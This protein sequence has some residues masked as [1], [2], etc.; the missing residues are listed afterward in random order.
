M[1]KLLLALGI[2]L[3]FASCDNGGIS[4]ESNPFVGAWEADDDGKGGG[5][6]FTENEVKVYLFDG[7]EGK[8]KRE[9]YLQSPASLY[10]F[11]ETTLTII[12]PDEYGVA[13]EDMRTTVV[14]YDFSKGKQF[15]FPNSSLLYKKIKSPPKFLN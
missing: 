5:R 2:V 13:T 14:P 12:V 11:D 9:A 1:K 8:V 15:S 4:E 3:I 7:P 10:V 6:L